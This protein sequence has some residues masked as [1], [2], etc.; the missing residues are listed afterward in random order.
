MVSAVQEQAKET[1]NQMNSEQGLIATLERLEQQGASKAKLEFGMFNYM[2]RKARKQGVPIKGTFELTPLCNLDCKMCY[3][4]LSTEQLKHSH[5]QMLSGEQWKQIMQDA[6]DHGMLYAL[7]TGG[8]AMLHPS[9]DELYLFLR[10]RGIQVTVN[11]N[12]LLLTPARIDF[13]RQHLPSELHITLYGADEDTYERVTGHRMF[14]QIWQNILAV[15]EAGI[16]LCVGIT[17]SKYMRDGIEPAVR[18]LQSLGVR[19]GVNSSLS[20]PREETG[21]SG[22][23]HDLSVSEYIHLHKQLQALSGLQTKSICEEDVPQPGGNVTEERRG[24]RCG[25]GRSAFSIVWYGGMQPCLS[26][27][28]IQADLHV[29]PFAKAWEYIFKSVSEYP[30]PRECFGCPYEGF[31]SVCVVRHALGAPV[32]HAN[33]AMCERAK[34]FFREGL[35]TITQQLDV[36]SKNDEKEVFGTNC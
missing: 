4:H 34:Q 20:D 29:L 33:P 28:H 17:P 5:K 16:P 13:F 24:F 25:G 7:L 36:G 22:F 30:V 27:E 23:D 31:C 14:K 1:E 26:A 15:K 18:L 2:E 3:V 32:G 35:V 6:I 19:Y 11:T 8:E 10:D 12:G 9:F 21:R